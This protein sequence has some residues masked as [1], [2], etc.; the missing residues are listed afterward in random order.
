VLGSALTD[1]YQAGVPHAIAGAPAEF[2]RRAHEALPA[3][4]ALAERLG[5]RG[6]TLASQAQAAFVD[7]LGLALVI[8][9][10]STVAAAAFV[11]W[12]AAERPLFASG[13]PTT[14]EE[15]Q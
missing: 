10:A 14:K 3:A 6:A 9:A 8:A 4:L 13:R 11:L 1:R 12:R 15:L 7:G 5:P 2:A